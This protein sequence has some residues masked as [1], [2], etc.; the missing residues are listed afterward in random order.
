MEAFLPTLL[1]LRVGTA[2][3]HFLCVLTY[4]K[5]MVSEESGLSKD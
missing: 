5:E 1:R 3:E 2:R 4:P